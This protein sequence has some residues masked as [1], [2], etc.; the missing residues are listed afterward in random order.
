MIGTITDLPIFSKILS[1]HVLQQVF[2]KSRK[3]A[4][5]FEQASTEEDVHDVME[6]LW[7]TCLSIPN[8]ILLQLFYN[9]RGCYGNQ[10]F[11]DISI[12]L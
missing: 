3:Q 6:E 5:S 9:M 8:G 7:M 11:L 12:D 2:L 4:F 1:F 10:N